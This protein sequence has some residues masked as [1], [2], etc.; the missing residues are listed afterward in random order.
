[1]VEGRIGSNAVVSMFSKS[2]F[3]LQSE[4]DL[5]NPVLISVDGAGSSWARS[6][7]WRM[8]A[9]GTHF[10]VEP[11]LLIIHYRTVRGAGSSN[12]RAAWRTPHPARRHGSAAGAGPGASGRR[13]PAAGTFRREVR[14]QVPT[15]VL[16][17]VHLGDVRR[18]PEPSG[19]RCRWSVCR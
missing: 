18:Q 6:A 9:W 11:D 1:V 3:V 14:L 15:V 17:R 5:C 2:V 10:T 12:A 4:V 8:A 7:T 13:P 16:M 19:A